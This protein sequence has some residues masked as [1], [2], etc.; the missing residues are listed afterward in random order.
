MDAFSAPR[1]GGDVVARSQC[2]PKYLDTRVCE[3]RR[4][5]YSVGTEKMDPDGLMGRRGKST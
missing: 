4:M 3:R 1:V 5:V 2:A